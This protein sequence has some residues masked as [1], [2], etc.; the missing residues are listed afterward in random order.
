MR[1]GRNTDL[2][3]YSQHLVIP[4]RTGTRVL[5][6]E[7]GS[8]WRLPSVTDPEWM[9]VGRAQSWV[10]DRFGLDIVVLRCV[11]VDEHDANEGSG[12]AYLFTE[13]LSDQT[14][15]DGSWLDQDATAAPMDARDRKAIRQWF[16]E[17]REGG[18][19][20]LQPWAYPGWYETAVDW[21]EASLPETV[22]VDQYATW[23]VSSLHRVE[24]VGGSLLLQGSA[25][26]LPA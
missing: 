26:R 1:K 19:Q 13:N 16:T 9:L 12:D 23:C 5:L 6:S 24:T 10:R 11:L 18:P 25:R 17:E 20:A 22:R 8:G 21:I 2:M 7:D 15:L 4:D 14:P 3:A